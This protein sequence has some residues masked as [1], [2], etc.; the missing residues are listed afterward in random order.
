[1]SPY[2]PLNVLKRNYCI[3]CK[4]FQITTA[5]EIAE[6]LG[7]GFEEGDPEEKVELFMEFVFLTVPAEVE[8]VDYRVADT[9]RT[10]SMCSLSP[11]PLGKK[12]ELNLIPF[13]KER[14]NSL[15]G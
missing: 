10:S 6:A 5:E 7:D 2:S 1:V 12:G 3:S 13:S 15:S 9:I 8:E 4:C 11:V 14:E